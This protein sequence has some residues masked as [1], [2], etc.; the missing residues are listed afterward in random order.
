M[1]PLMVRLCVPVIN[2]LSRWQVCVHVRDGLG[3]PVALLDWDLG[4]GHYRSGHHHRDME[5][6]RANLPLLLWPPPAGH[7]RA[8]VRDCVPCGLMTR[9]LACRTID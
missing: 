8:C 9:R 7:V 2:C 4:G 1:Q 5:R 3:A 6:Y